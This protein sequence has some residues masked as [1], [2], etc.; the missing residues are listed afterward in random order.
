MS[1]LA[2]LRR[3]RELIAAR[4]PNGWTPAEHRQKLAELDER[5]HRRLRGPQSVP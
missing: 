3:Q 1:I 2:R 5:I 4:C